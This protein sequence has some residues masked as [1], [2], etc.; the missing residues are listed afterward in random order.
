MKNLNR[1]IILSFLILLT[2]CK[3]EKNNDA[4]TDVKFEKSE[5]LGRWIRINKMEKLENSEDV[6]VSKFNLKENYTAEI[7]ILD[8]KG[9]RTITGSWKLD[10]E[11]KLGS[12][13]FKS[14]VA[15]TFDK[16]TNHRNVI[17]LSVEDSNKK[18]ILT[19]QKANFEKE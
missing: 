8:S 1:L 7:E 3:F 15:L 9:N 13:S 14:D 16:D 17:L 6:I 4:N 11:Q 12:I 19:A 18:M 2:S 5:L 10:G